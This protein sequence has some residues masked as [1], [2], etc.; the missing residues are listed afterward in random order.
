MFDAACAPVRGKKVSPPLEGSPFNF[1]VKSEDEARKLAS[2][3]KNAHWPGIRA[4]AQ[5]SGP[6]GVPWVDWN[7]WQVR[8]MLARDSAKP[9]WV[10]VT[11]PAAASPAS[12]EAAVADAA[13]FGGRWIASA[14]QPSWARVS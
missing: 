12:Y 7:G 1:T 11:P 4:I 8:M 14:S 9:A 3:T 6:T 10:D 2:L 5:S 13:A